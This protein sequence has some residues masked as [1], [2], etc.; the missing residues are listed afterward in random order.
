[1]AFKASEMSESV[2]ES[3]DEVITRKAKEEETENDDD[4]QALGDIGYIMRTCMFLIK[5]F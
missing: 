2:L 4:R 3:Q 1:M 5:Y